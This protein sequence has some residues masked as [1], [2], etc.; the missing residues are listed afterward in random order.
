MMPAE[1]RAVRM[2]E[3]G[4]P[5]VLRV[6]SVPVPARGAGQVL[7]RVDAAG[8]NPIDWKMRRGLGSARDLPRPSTLGYD[9]SGT[10]IDG[11]AGSPWRAGDLVFG[12]VNFH[13]PAGCY[14]DYVVAPIAQIARIPAG[15]SHVNAAALPLAALTA[16]QAVHDTA[17]VQR[18]D[19]VL[20]HAAAGGVGHLAAQFAKRA[21]AHV[22]GTASARNHDFVRSLGVDE[23]ID[24][25]GVR[26]EEVVGEID[27]AIETTGSQDV[28]NRTALV[29]RGGGRIVSLIGAVK[30]EPLRAR[31]ANAGYMIVHADAEQL[32]RIGALVASGEVRL[33]IDRVMPL[34]SAAEAHRLSEG[35]RTRGKLVLAM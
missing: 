23:V 3:F 19:R 22:I 12:M 28:A 9:M 7:V 18:G 11:D 35:G 8:V 10:V 17:Q 15:L 21:G 27:A 32:A 13:S 14:A 2:H 26:F 5:E 1:M 30:L 34:E 6:E 24:Y 4:E 16:W 33:Q 31:G 20:V 29:M 25:S